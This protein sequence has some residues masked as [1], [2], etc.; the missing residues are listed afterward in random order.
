MFRTLPLAILLGTSQVTMDSN[1]VMAQTMS[2]VQNKLDTI[3]VFV[4]SADGIPTPVS[5]ELEGKTRNVYFAAFSETAVN[6][7]VKDLKKKE[8]K[9]NSNI[10][11]FFKKKKEQASKDSIAGNLKFQPASLTKFDS[12]IQ[13][14]LDKDTNARVIYVPDPS[15]KK[16]SKDLLLSQG[17]KR[18]TL[19]SIIDKVP[20]VFCPKPSLLA[21]VKD[22]PRKGETFVPCSTDYQTVQDIVEKSVALNPAVK[23]QK[24]KVI[25]ITLP[26]FVKMLSSG[27]ENEVDKIRVLTTPSSLKF[28]K[29]G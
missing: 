16:Y 4:P 25:A 15:Q 27:K 10:F 1:P 20:V 19:N 9:K 14:I 5:Y 18:K 23:K 2:V 3:I 28:I 11:G 12:L 29:K 26:Q 21:T 7:L 24:P 17:V 6:D 13:P 22:G 8:E